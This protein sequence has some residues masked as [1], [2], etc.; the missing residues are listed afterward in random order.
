LK[1]ERGV[2]AWRIGFIFRLRESWVSI[3]AR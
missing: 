2:T 3:Y 1:C